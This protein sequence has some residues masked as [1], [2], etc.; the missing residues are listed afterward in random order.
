MTTTDKKIPRIIRYQ[1]RDVIVVRMPNNTRQGFYKS[2]GRN[3]GMKD[4][5]F[6]FDGWMPCYPH[7]WFIKDN[8]C[9]IQG[10]LHRYGTQELKNVSDYLATLEI[11]QGKVTEDGRW[12]NKYIYEARCFLRYKE[13]K[14]KEKSHEVS[15]SR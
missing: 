4:T 13:P 5:W 14:K 8:Y 7:G 9:Q 3:S 2:S 10:D 15:N 12:I 1:N 11:P 6:P